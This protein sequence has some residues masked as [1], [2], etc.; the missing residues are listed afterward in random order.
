MTSSALISEGFN[1]MLFGMGFV[2]LF[3]SLLVL[4]TSTMSRFILRFFPDSVPVSEP[5][6]TH[7]SESG[8]DAAFKNS[9]LVAVIG[10]AIRMHRTKNN[11]GNKK[12]S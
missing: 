3:L 5:S 4:M 12:T 2:C 8:T 9:E 11:S 10:A 7:K 6:S 1:L